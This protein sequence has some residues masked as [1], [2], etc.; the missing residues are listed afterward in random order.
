MIH[1]KI[2][3][4]ISLIV[5]QHVIAA[6]DTWVRIDQLIQNETGGDYGLINDTSNRRRLE[7]QRL[8]NVPDIE[9]DKYNRGSVLLTLTCKGISSSTVLSYGVLRDTLVATTPIDRGDEITPYN[10]AIQR[11]AISMTT[12]LPDY[13]KK[14]QADRS[15]REGTI[16]DERVTDYLPDIEAGES[17][18][19]RE[20]G[21]G[22]TISKI[23]KALEDGYVGDTIEIFDGSNKMGVVIRHNSSITV[24]IIE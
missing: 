18:E 15:I 23:V 20:Q 22:F 6:P 10:A 24:K 2:L 5:S 14:L 12:S 17:V 13:T 3:V 21:A 11:Q 7:N 8:C 1:L 16:I 9:I 19:I 4:V